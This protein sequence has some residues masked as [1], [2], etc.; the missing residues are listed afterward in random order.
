MQVQHALS[1]AAKTFPAARTFYLAGDL[2][3]VLLGELGLTRS[4][5]VSLN[6][7]GDQD[8]RRDVLVVPDPAL[9]KG[10]IEPVIVPDAWVIKKDER[11]PR[12]PSSVQKRKR[13]A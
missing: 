1:E 8:E 2:Y 12:K 3:S 4:P 5:V 9:K 11:K 10:T 13:K 7:P 6:L